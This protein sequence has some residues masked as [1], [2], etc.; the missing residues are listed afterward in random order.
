MLRTGQY[1]LSHLL[2]MSFW[3]ALCI[4]FSRQ[5]ILLSLQVAA[6]IP[7]SQMA[8]W[9]AIYGAMFC[10]SVV[11]G[12]CFKCMRAGVAAGTAMVVLN[13]G[14]AGAKWLFS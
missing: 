3:I 12:G 8:T 5:V 9:F 10:L 2:L 7:P 6:P 14:I 4:G 11:V 13:L 1:S